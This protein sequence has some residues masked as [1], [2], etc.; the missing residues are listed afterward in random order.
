MTFGKSL[1]KILKEQLSKDL[2]SYFKSV[3][4]TTEN[5]QNGKAVSL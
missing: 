4:S 2:Q 1:Q 3:A 5:Y